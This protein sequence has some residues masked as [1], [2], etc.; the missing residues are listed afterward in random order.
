MRLKLID[1]RFYITKTPKSV[2]QIA[3]ALG[4]ELLL[5][6]EV[7]IENLAPIES[8]GPLDLA[9]LSNDKY[10]KLLS[11]SAAGAI[12]VK[13]GL[14]VP[15]SNFILSDNPYYSYAKAIEL[16][17]CPYPAKS[18]THEIDPSAKIGKNAIIGHN[19]VIEEDVEIGDNA[20]IASGTFIGRGV[21]IGNNARIDHAVTISYSIIGDNVVILPGARIGQDGFG[22][23]T[24]KGRHYKIFHLG[25]VI[26]GNDVEIG[27][28]STIDRGSLQDTIISDGVRVDNLVQIGHNVHIG[29]GSIIVAQAGVAGS[30]KIGS[31]CALGG[32]VGISGH[33]TIADRVQVAGQGGVIQDVKEEGVILGGT[34]A[35]H[36]KDW[37][38][39]SITLKNLVKNKR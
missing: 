32:Q 34:P 13:K 16:F 29:R 21:K 31:Y 37:H 11:S 24:E 8:A 20:Q 35:V 9:F 28:N 2:Q 30:S 4:C 6:H 22:F 12:I 18:S 3:E 26:I 39:Q 10:A 7:M 23:A 25:R 38:K 1:K 14:E 5:G 36:L 15:G 27:A 17:Y 33:I 19:V